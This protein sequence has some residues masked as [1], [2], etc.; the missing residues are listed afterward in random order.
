MKKMK[1][2]A[3]VAVLGVVG[4]AL[5]QEMVTLRRVVKEGDKETYQITSNIK[6]I[7]SN[8]MMGEQEVTITSSQKMALDYGKTTDGKTD[9]NVKITDIKMEMGG[10]MAAMAGDMASQM[11][12]ELT[13]TAKLDEFNNM[14]DYKMGSGMTGMGAQMMQMMSGGTQGMLTGITFPK[15]PIAV[16]GTWDIKVPENKAAGMG[17]A[18]MKATLVG[19]EKVGARDAWKITYS[20]A[21]PMNMD[22]K[23]MQGMAD[24]PMGQMSFTITGTLDT[25][26]T[27]LVEKGTGKLLQMDVKIGGKQKMEMT[28][29]GM[30]MD[31]RG[32]TTMS[33]KLIN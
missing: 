22:S 32:D 15:D 14:T 23:N 1:T 20:G 18:T 11:P 8:D 13:G 27:L 9:V 19:A 24:S 21:L 3:L 33:V 4:F 17:A 31:M 6:Q 30:T 26:G 5:A 12:K 7:I 25:S 10:P 16:G 29:M 2:A 28:D